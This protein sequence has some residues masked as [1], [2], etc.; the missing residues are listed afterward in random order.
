MKTKIKAKDF[1]KALFGANAN[2]ILNG[3]SGSY[4]DGSE[5]DFK[6]EYG[7]SKEEARIYVQG[8]IVSKIWK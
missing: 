4:A 7:L 1:L 6:N 5:K 8:F 3:M 2:Y